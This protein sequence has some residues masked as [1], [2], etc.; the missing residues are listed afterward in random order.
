M[1]VVVIILLLVVAY[2]L[3]QRA[4][5]RRFP[6]HSGWFDCDPDN[7]LMKIAAVLDRYAEKDEQRAQENY[8]IESYQKAVRVKQWPMVYFRKPVGRKGG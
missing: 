5:T 8:E 2:L 7:N 4:H 6:T 3:L 1:T